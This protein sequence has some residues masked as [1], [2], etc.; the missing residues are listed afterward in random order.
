[1]AEYFQKWIGT[2]SGSLRKFL[3]NKWE[4][5]LTRKL[6]SKKLK[7]CIQII[8]ILSLVDNVY[9]S[10]ITSFKGF[11]LSIIFTEFFA[12]VNRISTWSKF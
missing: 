10:K 4:K 5:L 11:F 1:M 8:N 6:E 7:Y 12:T 3:T 2:K 9:F